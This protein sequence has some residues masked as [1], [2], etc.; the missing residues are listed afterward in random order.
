M[1]EIQLT[2]GGVTLV[3]D[4]D[5]R[6]LSKITWQSCDGRYASHHHNTGTE[7]KLI[8]MHNVI[9]RSIGLKFPPGHEVDHKNRDGLDNQRHNLRVVTKSINMYKRSLMSTNTTGIS[10]V[11]WYERYHKWNA[12]IKIRGQRMNLGYFVKFEDAVAA[13]LAAEV[14]YLGGEY[15]TNLP[16]PASDRAIN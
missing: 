16:G 2:N 10:G 15:T 6:L 13:R 14:R 1:K 11:N 4:E 7:N 9:A 5:H 3:D 8:K 12:T